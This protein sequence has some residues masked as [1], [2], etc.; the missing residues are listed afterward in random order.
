MNRFVPQDLAIQVVRKIKEDGLPY[1][2]DFEKHRLLLQSATAAGAQ[3]EGPV[4]RLP[5]TLSSH[6]IEIGGGEM[7][8][9]PDAK[10][11][12]LLIQSGHCA[13][14]FFEGKKNLDHKV[15]RAYM[16]RKKQGKSQIK[17]LKTKGK[18]RAG[19]RVRLAGTVEFFE[20]INERLQSYFDNFQIDRIAISCSKTLLPF[21]FNSKVNTPFEKN[22]ERLYRIPRHVHVPKYEEMM[23][24]QKFLSRGEWIYEEAHLPLIHQLLEEDDND[25][26]DEEE[27]EIKGNGNFSRG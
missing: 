1:V 10:Y 23:E 15:F 9:K 25:N 11:I 12:M 2:Y 13:M 3:E 18:S 8:V 19:S 16:V 27:N 20:N 7:E 4:F 24:V 22:D 14:G 6:S 5:L 26:T 21:L 17:H